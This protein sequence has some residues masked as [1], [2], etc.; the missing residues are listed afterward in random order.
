MVIIFGQHCK[1]F[2]IGRSEITFEDYDK[3]AKETHKE[4]PDDTGYGRGQKPAINVS[5]YDAVAYTVW[6]SEQTGYNYRLPTEAE[7]EYAS[8]TGSSTKFWWGDNIYAQKAACQDCDYNNKSKG[9]FSV[10]SF[11]QNLFGLYDTAG[12]VWE[13][14]CN[15][16]TN[17]YNNQPCTDIGNVSEQT[18]ITIRGGSWKYTHDYMTST[19][20]I[21]E[22][23]KSKRNDLG[24]RVV[25]ELE[26]P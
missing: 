13:W 5:W 15:E 7:W 14:T 25:R 1:K 3:F 20:R 10:K 6:L 18:W 9:P 8:S 11:E 17:K 16:Y 26:S 19:S 22:S 2:A 23:A 21:M 24:F 4:L 12:N